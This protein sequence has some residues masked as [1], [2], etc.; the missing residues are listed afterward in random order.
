MRSNTYLGIELG[1]ARIKAIAINENHIP[2]SAGGLH[3]GQLL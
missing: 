2:L 1:P 3:L